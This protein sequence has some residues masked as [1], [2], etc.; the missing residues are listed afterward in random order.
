TSAGGLRAVDR[1]VLIVERHR[2]D[3]RLPLTCATERDDV[4][5]LDRDLGGGADVLAEGREHV[6]E[7]LIRE[8]MALDELQHDRAGLVLHDLI[9]TQQERVLFEEVREERPREIAAV[10]ANDDRLHPALDVPDARQPSA[11]RT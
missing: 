7:M 10:A 11:T 3:D 5:E 9:L 6:R 8:A 4:N 2:G 1:D